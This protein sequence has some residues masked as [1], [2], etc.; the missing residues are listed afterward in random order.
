MK[1]L[2]ISDA[3]LGRAQYHLSEREE[4]YYLSFT[5]ALKRGA[6]ADVVLVTGDLFDTKRPP[7]RA[8]V[9]FVEAVE[10][11]GAPIYLIGGTTTLAMSVL[12]T[13]AGSVYTTQPL[14]FWKEWG[15]RA[16]S[17]GRGRTWGRVYLRGLRYAEGVRCGV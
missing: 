4:D 17:V 16:S 12:E 6:G 11:V 3:H 9:K 8:L 5:E 2:H 14:G 1:I 15:W 13:A 7:T 10:G